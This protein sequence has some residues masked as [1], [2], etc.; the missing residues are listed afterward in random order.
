MMINAE[1]RVV[2]DPFR[3]EREFWERMEP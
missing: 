3:L 1:C 2:D